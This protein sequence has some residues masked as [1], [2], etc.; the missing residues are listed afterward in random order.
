MENK[1]LYLENKAYKMRVDI[2]KMTTQAGSG[3]PTSALSCT[4][5]VSALFFYSLK[6]NFE[7]PYDQNNDRFI[8][9]KGHAVPVLYAAY[10]ELG[11]LTETDILK[12]RSIDSNLEGHPT[13][14]FIYNEAATGSLGQGL[15]IALG[16]ALSARLSKKDFYTYVLLGDSEM[17]EGSIWEAIELAAVYKLHNLIAI[18]DLNRLGQSTETIDDHKPEVHAKRW[19]AFGWHAI[20]ING[21][22][23]NQ[24]IESLDIA[25]SIKSMPIVIIALTLKGYGVDIAQDKMGYHGKVFNQKELPD[26]LKN[27]EKRF[28]Q[29]AQAIF[30]EVKKIIP[31]PVK[32]ENENINFQVPAYKKD[33]LIATRLAYGQSL[34]I[35]GSY[36]SKVLSLDAEVKNSTFAELF[37]QKFPDRF[38]QCYVAEQNMIGMATGLTQRRYIPFSSTFASF[39]SRAYDQIRMAAIGKVPLRIV[40]SHAGISIG[41]DG[42]SQMGLE[43]IAL[44][45]VL[46]ESIILYPS[47]AVSTY[48]L[49]NLMANYNLG[50]SYLRLTRGS[51]PVIYDNG[52]KFKIGG[53]KI[54]RQSDNDKACIIAAGITVFEALKA[55]ENL[56]SS[57][58]LV[59]V[60][61][62]Y[63]VK[64][65]D[66]E[67]IINIAKKSNNKIFTVEDHYMHGG[68]GQI[69]SV[70]LINENIKIKV[71]AVNGLPKSGKPE[72][73]LSLFKIDSKAIIDEVKNS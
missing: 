36:S 68:I 22:D 48:N 44:F 42:P 6:Y 30:P 53:C 58:I 11:I 2:L 32:P 9:S 73:L 43:D 10:K 54:L 39:L 60:I 72:E 50:I 49:V 19:E 35:L 41:Q 64:P 69:I 52:E 63:S 23:M 62:L 5:I 56:K 61:D 14:R 13:S 8:L 34:T 67:T 27:L 38:I 28:S 15:S 17:T 45:N 51:T 70:A 55:Y 46:P 21:H 33:D 29:A 4:D 1:I 16:M 3:H 40:G 37:E 59:S 65:I 18:V 26:I 24:I 7:N 20:I 71:L 66:T 25:R 47:D 31:N 57:G 12:Y